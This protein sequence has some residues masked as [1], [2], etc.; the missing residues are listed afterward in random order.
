MNSDFRP[1]RGSAIILAI[2]IG[3]YDEKIFGMISP[4]SNS[5]KVTTTILI[6]N[7]QPEA[8]PKSINESISP[9]ARTTM[10][11]LTRLLAIKIVASR[12]FSAESSV[13]IVLLV[14]SLFFLNRSMSCGE[15]EKKAV[16]EADTMAEMHNSKTIN[17][18]MTPS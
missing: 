2:R 11:T 10:Q 16:S 4:N 3:L 12:Y 6:R 17:D 7:S 5:R 14:R 13:M 15:S 9:L 18:R 8:S 1:D